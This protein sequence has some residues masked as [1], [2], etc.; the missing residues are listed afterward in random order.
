MTIVKIDGYPHLIESQSHREE[1]W[2]DGY[3][4]V[5]ENLISKVMSLQGFFDLVFDGDAL[6]DVVEN[7]EKYKEYIS[8]LPATD[9][10]SLESL[11]EEKIQKSKLDLE[12][13]LKANPLTWTD[14]NRYSNYKTSRKQR[15]WKTFIFSFVFYDS[16]LRSFS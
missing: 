5:P 8:S 14:G 16:I 1:V 15:E 9:S 6:V 12:E 10:R 7:E 2:L 13:Y 3:I 4:E 11:K